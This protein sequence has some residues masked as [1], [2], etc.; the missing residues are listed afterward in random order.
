MIFE[1]FRKEEREREELDECEL[2]CLKCKEVI[3]WVSSF[4]CSQNDAKEVKHNNMRFFFPLFTEWTRN[5]FIE[6]LKP[7]CTTKNNDICTKYFS[8]EIFKGNVFLYLKVSNRN[9]SYIASA[10]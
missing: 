5:I 9:D 2:K 7:K 10:F 6:W 3:S 8:K 1:T 4:L